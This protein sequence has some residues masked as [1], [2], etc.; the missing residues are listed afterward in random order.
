MICSCT[1][2]AEWRTSFSPLLPLFYFLPVFVQAALKQSAQT[3]YPVVFPLAR[4]KTLFREELALLSWLNCYLP[5]SCWNNIQ[6]LRGKSSLHFVWNHSKPN[7]GS[8]LRCMVTC[9]SKG[10]TS[11][12]PGRHR[13]HQSRGRTNQQVCGLPGGHSHNLQWSQSTLLS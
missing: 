2:W 13:G 4:W 3:A 6:G 11:W 10:R 9:R 8:Q 7:R 12:Q 1:V 5:S